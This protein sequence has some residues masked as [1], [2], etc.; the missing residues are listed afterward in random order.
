MAN[1]YMEMMAEVIELSRQPSLRHEAFSIVASKHGKKEATFRT[2]FHRHRDEF[3]EFCPTMKFGNETEELLVAICLQHAAIRVPLDFKCFQ[4]ICFELTQS[5]ISRK[6]MKEFVGRHSDILSLRKGKLLSPKRR[7]VHLLHETDAFV[8]EWGYLIDKGLVHERNL[9]VCDESRIGFPGQEREVI[10]LL[11]TT[12]SCVEQ[13][14]GEALCTYLP[15]SRPDGSTPFRVYIFKNPN[16]EDESSMMEIPK[17]NVTQASE[18]ANGVHRQLFLQNKTGYL[19]TAL[20][21]VILTEFHAWW[22]SIHPNLDCYILSD[23]LKVHRDADILQYSLDNHM[24]LWSIMAGTSHWF[25][26][27][28]QY[29]FGLLKKNLKTKV[30]SLSWDPDHSAKYR[31]SLLA[32]CFYEA[33]NIAMRKPVVKAAFKHVGLWP[34]DP[35]LIKKRA[36]EQHDLSEGVATTK[37]IKEAADAV[38]RTLEDSKNKQNQTTRFVKRQKSSLRSSC[39]FSPQKILEDC[40]RRESAKM[41]KPKKRPACGNKDTPTKKRKAASSSRGSK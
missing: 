13:W 12:G 18:L 15:F 16:F 7:T 5:Q 34:W 22:V 19:D 10:T 8:D 27:H 28:N 39:L 35:N 29:P 11:N 40:K 38:K 9:F 25:Q 33:E 24:Y 23:Q 32:G 41:A 17:P 6:Y 14:R 2:W 20:Y 3:P 21:K 31:N 1:E 37:L 36:Q 4:K 26:V 30:E